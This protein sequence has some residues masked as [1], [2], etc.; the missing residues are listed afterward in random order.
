MNRPWI[1]NYDPM[2]KPSLSY[3]DKTMYEMLV[4]T[5]EHFPH[6]AALSFEGQEINFKT[7]LF[8]VDTI[9]LALKDLGLK[10]GDVATICLPN[11]PQ[12]VI[13][14][15]AVNKIGV[16]ANMVHPKTPVNGLQESIT[17]TRSKYL[18]ILDAFLPKHVG[19][20]AEIKI[21]RVFTAAIGDYLSPVKA[22]GFYVTQGHKIP[23][24]PGDKKYMSW[25]DLHKCGRYARIASES[26]A[27]NAVYKR[28]SEPSDPAV[29]LHS[30]GTT[31]SPKTIVLSSM[32]MN[33]LAVAG[34]QI[35]NIPDPFETGMPPERSMVTI[36]PLFHGFG[37]CMGMHTMMCN[38]ITSILVPQFEP[39]KLAKVIMKEKPSFIA[40]VPTLY[41]GILK[42]TLLQKAQLPFLKCCFAGGDSLSPDLKDRFETFLHEHGAPISLREGYGLTET[43][44][45]CCVNPEIK[46]R[47]DSVGLPLPDMDMMITASGTNEEVPCRT[48]GEICVSGPT[49]MLEYLDD[50]EATAEA[51]HVHGDGRRWVHTGDYGF[52]D[53]DGFFHFTQRLKRIIKVSGIPV[54]PSQ[55]EAVI[56]KVD[57]VGA[58]CAIAVPDA[59]R[60]HVVKAIV[61]PASF[62]AEEGLLKIKED[63][64]AACREKL[65]SY[66]RPVDIEFRDSLPK[67]LV[68]KIDYVALE[69][70]ASESSAEALS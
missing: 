54:F 1:Q 39:D 17:S 32:N 23:K 59:Y 10:C 15:Y 26:L 40:A 25:S 14:F 57:G 37:L 12:A 51:I 27:S 11:I 2:M 61:V 3:P 55:I 48:H 33:A 53:E 8:H 41:E 50:P 22:L 30:G 19:M 52:M 18:I 65:I 35:V 62:S 67:T 7:L 44:T 60:I 46:C 16:I 43:V 20:L 45:V 6:T 34:P 68:G 5:A 28:S 24:I 63:I 64:N 56:S 38:A 21:E 69:K 13:F 36:L 58:V 29:Y 49:V 9:A 47:K 31:G 4:R 70:E 42:S 66:A